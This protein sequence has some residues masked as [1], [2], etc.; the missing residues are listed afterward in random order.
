MKNARFIVGEIIKEIEERVYATPFDETLLKRFKDKRIR[1]EDKVSL[2]FSRGIPAEYVSQ[3][4]EILGSEFTECLDQGKIGSLVWKGK[5]RVQRAYK[6]LAI[7]LESFKYYKKEAHKSALEVECLQKIKNELTESQ[8][9]H[10]YEAERLEALL[11]LNEML[12]E[13]VLEPFE[14][15]IKKVVSYLK[16]KQ[17]EVF[18]FDD[19]KFLA[20]ELKTDGETFIYNKEEVVPAQPETVSEVTLHEVQETSLAVPLVAEGE[21][22]GHFRVLRQTPADFDK[23][24]WQKNVKRITPVLAR[25]IEAN[26]NRI[27]TRKVYIDDLTRLY[28]K[29]KLNEQMGKLFTLFKQ[30][31]KKLFIAMLDIDRFKALN[32]TFGHP[33]GDQILKLTAGLIKAEVPDSYRYGGEEFVAI[34]YGNN[35]KEVI[36]TMERLRQKIEDTAHSIDDREYRITISVGIAEFETYMNSVMDAI[37]RADQALYESK[38]D[39]RNRCTY[40]DDVKDRLTNDASRLKKEIKKLQKQ[41]DR[42]SVLEK[43]NKRLTEQIK[44]GKGKGKQ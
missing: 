18:L 43:E 5:D 13:I 12:I 8:I 34:F 10:V 3:M 4:K 37:D 38:S 1:I 9:S 11:K 17:I 44:K 14:D 16:A 15:A 20:A 21:Q 33:V 2:D 31:E 22:I 32:D 7:L 36:E 42:T 29:R 26:R 39:G 35:K 19:D 41:L 30:G 24:A 27:Q 28:N 25:I 23:E 40:Y 6:K